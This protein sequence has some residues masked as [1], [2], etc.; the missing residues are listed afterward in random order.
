MQNFKEKLKMK[1]IKKYIKLIVDSHNKLIISKQQLTNISE[2]TRRNQLMDMM[3]NNKNNFRLTGPIVSENG[4]YNNSFVTYSYSDLTYY[5]SEFDDKG[6]VIEC[7]IVKQKVS[8]NGFKKVFFDEGIDRF[9]NK[10]PSELNFAGFLT[11]CEDDNYHAMINQYI[12]NF[13]LNNLSDKSNDFSK[14][15][16]YKHKY[17]NI[18]NMYI[19]LLKY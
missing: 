19:I 5:P 7:K 14:D 8:E 4:N 15:F 2:D 1:I 11:F 9:K 3:K 13:N 12:S 17:A 10:Y 16:I 18:D 6:M